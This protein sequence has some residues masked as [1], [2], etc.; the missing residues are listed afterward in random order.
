M[1][2]IVWVAL[3]VVAVT[4]IL[5]YSFYNAKA[6]DTVSFGD[7]GTLTHEIVAVYDDGTEE[8]VYV[9]QVNPVSREFRFYRTYPTSKLYGVYYRIYGTASYT[10]YSQIEIGA[11]SFAL[12]LT[13]RKS[14]NSLIWSGS[15]GGMTTKTYSLPM[16]NVIIYDKM[17]SST[18][19]PSLITLDS[20]CGS[21]AGQV[22]FIFSTSGSIA[23]R[24]V[25]GPWQY[26]SSS[27]TQSASFYRDTL[28]H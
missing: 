19:T 7:I 20:A 23:Y 2:R 27:L 26:V 18:S 15:L 14:D 13:L 4:A 3:L 28:A 1:K 11:G 10:G 8:I 12:Q 24:G 25:G 22:A 6:T 21:Y 17:I 9:N 16:N 5:L